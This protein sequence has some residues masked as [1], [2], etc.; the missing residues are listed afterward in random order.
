MEKEV[1]F[2]ASTKNEIVCTLQSTPL[3]VSV[4]FTWFCN[5]LK[6][7][8]YGNNTKNSITEVN[9]NGSSS[10]IVFG[11]I[12]FDQSGYCKCEVMQNQLGRSVA[13]KVNVGGKQNVLSLFI[14]E[15]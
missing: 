7:N 4:S 9:V 1:W 14:D 8:E 11:N 15:L 12:S 5:N 2:R 13:V 10:K 3:N 6:I